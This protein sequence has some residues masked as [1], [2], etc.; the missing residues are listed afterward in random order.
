MG[1]YE[2]LPV[3]VIWF[4]VLYGVLKI[5]AGLLVVHY[6]KRYAKRVREEGR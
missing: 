3:G 6:G 5:A 1:F 2:V 4:P